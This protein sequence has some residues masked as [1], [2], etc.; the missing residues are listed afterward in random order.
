MK[1]ESPPFGAGVCLQNDEIRVTS[2]WGWR[3]GQAPTNCLI[4]LARCTRQ[5]L[6]AQSCVHH[7]NFTE[8]MAQYYALLPGQV[9]GNQHSCS[10]IRLASS[11]TTIYDELHG[12]V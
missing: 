12:N 5:V 1:S 2:I 3:L 8:Y 6:H 4:C 11:T 9:S 10:V 7:I